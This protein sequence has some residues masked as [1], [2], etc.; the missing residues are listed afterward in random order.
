MWWRWSARTCLVAAALAVVELALAATF[1]PLMRSSL[2]G[3]AAVLHQAFAV[4]ALALAPVA[5]MAA[6]I[7]RRWGERLRSRLEATEP[8]PLLSQLVGLAVVVV[9]VL[10]LA[11]R[12]ARYPEFPERMALVVG[13]L[14]LSASVVT[15]VGAQ[16]LLRPVVGALAARW[17]PLADPR[18]ALPSLA[19]V[20]ALTALIAAYVAFGALL[21]PGLSALAALVAMALAL[22]AAAMARPASRAP[23]RAPL[24][25][26]ALAVALA[27]LSSCRHPLGSY[28]LH[29]HALAAGAL[30]AELGALADVDGDGAVSTWLGG[31]DC[32][33]F[34]ADRG[35]GRVEVPGD[36][37]DQDCRGGDAPAPSSAPADP[38]GPSAARLAAQLG[39]EIPALQG[40]LLV[41]LDAVRADALSPT[42]TPALTALRQR[43]LDF[44]RAYSPAASTIESMGGLLSGSALTARLDPESATL[45]HQIVQRTPTLPRLLAGGGRRLRSVDNLALPEALVDG[46]EPSFPWWLD[47]APRNGK[48]RFEAAAVTNET[49]RLL[50]A[51]GSAPFFFW[52]HYTDAHAPYLPLH[53]SLE[54]VSDYEREVAYVDMHLGRLL[55]YLDRSGLSERVALVVTADHGEEL[56]ARLVEGHGRYLYE[57]SVHVPLLVHVPGCPPARIDRPV[58]LTQVAPTIA[59]LLDVAPETPTLAEPIVVVV[60][61]MDRDVSHRAVVGE[62]F[63]LVVDVRHGGRVLFDL[64]ADPEETT[65]VLA[66]HPAQA[67]AL[68]AA[69]QRFLDQGGGAVPASPPEGDSGHR[70]RK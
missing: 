26:L 59:A 37:V 44:A 52:T 70:A 27:P 42:T 43:S 32:A 13:S 17:P 35:P 39:C 45:M 50:S 6:F 69:Y 54:E 5:A 36:G 56:G 64:E 8:A 40:A 22:L 62:R 57:S 4:Y 48:E 68:D 7:D 1:T 47:S 53:G 51:T 34:D 18:V 65:D 58:S 10:A 30:A 38:Q 66:A 63:K 41:V 67:A 25:A 19:A 28:L 9:I 14:A 55:A 16:V 3:A 29:N 61:T 23:A 12:G 60:E 24:A 21:L 46:F 15:M 2:V 31:T 33:A 20:L 11:H 49:I